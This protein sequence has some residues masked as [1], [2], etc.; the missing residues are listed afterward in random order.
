VGEESDRERMLDG[1]NQAIEEGYKYKEKGEMEGE[2]ER[3]CE[4]E[5][6]RKRGR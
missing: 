2:N 6:E 4:R 3:E 5:S 1:E